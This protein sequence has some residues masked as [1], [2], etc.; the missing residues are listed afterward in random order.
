MPIK[1]PYPWQTDDV[2]LNERL[3]ALFDQALSPLV[4]TKSQRPERPAVGTMYYDTT[5]KKPIWWDG[6]HWKDATGVVV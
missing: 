4:G 6:A 2:A 5:L 3:R 1:D